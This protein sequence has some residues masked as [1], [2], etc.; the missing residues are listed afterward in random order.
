MERLPG[1][2]RRQPSPWCLACLAYLTPSSPPSTLAMLSVSGTKLSPNTKASFT[3]GLV[4]GPSLGGVLYVLGGF[5]RSSTPGHVT[6]WKIRRTEEDESV[7]KK[8]APDLRR[9]CWA[10]IKYPQ[11]CEISDVH[12]EVSQWVSLRLLALN[13]SLKQ[14]PTTSSTSSMEHWWSLWYILW[15]QFFLPLEK[16]I[17]S[18]VYTDKV[19][20]QWVQSPAWTS[21]LISPDVTLHSHLLS[22]RNECTVYVTLWLVI[23]QFL[24][25]FVTP[26]LVW[27]FI[28]KN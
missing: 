16:D 12:D 7:Y 26:K 25:V 28:N 27:C 14:Q 22:C 21:W 19:L 17:F 24:S 10:N 6:H 23:E 20:L 9:L 8:Q 2:W 13:P 3:L 1:S 15:Y 11:I 5:R 18:D 4:L